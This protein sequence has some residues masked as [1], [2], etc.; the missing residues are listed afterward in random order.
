[1]RPEVLIREENPPLDAPDSGPVRVT[2]TGL[3]SGSSAGRLFFA[4]GVF[5]RGVSRKVELNATKV[6]VCALN[7]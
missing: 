1:M 5:Q 3:P 4:D 7:E 2:G 6:T